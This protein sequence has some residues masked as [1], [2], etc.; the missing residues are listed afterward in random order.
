MC[1]LCVCVCFHLCACQD[2]EAAKTYEV[3]TI[4]W[5]AEL[6]LDLASS[7]QLSDDLVWKELLFSVLT[8]IAD[9]NGSVLKDLLL[10]LCF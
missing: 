4:R 5:L 10:A 6:E 2:L 7:H 1:V 3:N 8:K 9:D